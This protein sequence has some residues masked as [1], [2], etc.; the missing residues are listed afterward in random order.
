MARHSTSHS[1]RSHRG[2]G[3][4]HARP[5]LAEQQRHHLRATAACGSLALI[6]GAAVGAALMYAFDPAAGRQRRQRAYDTT[7]GALGSAGNAV[8]SAYHYAGDA[9]GGALGYAADQLRS[10][11]RTV[12]DAASDA[13]PDLPSADDLS[14][15][16]QALRNRAAGAADS[17]R[18]AA[19]RRYHAWLD[20]ARAMIPRRRRPTDVS[21]FSAGAV[22]LGALRRRHG[23]HVA[24]RS[25]PRPR[26]DARGLS[27]RATAPSTKPATSCAPPAGIYATRPPACTTKPPRWSPTPISPKAPAPLLKG[28]ATTHPPSRSPP[29]TATS[30]SPA[31]APTDIVDDV[32]HALHNIKGVL[33]I[34]NNLQVTD[35]H[36]A[37]QRAASDLSA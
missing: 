27:R 18:N 2:N 23:R 3:R 19:S 13:L 11:A 31:C 28:S 8:G 29:K 30:D 36:A 32:L 16:G 12:T 20:S 17:Y 9:V 14:E 35:M 26:H 24:L 5:T 7:R 33:G 10:G 22:V 6:T 4:S 1:T 21:V 15:A 34:E 37:E 25:Q